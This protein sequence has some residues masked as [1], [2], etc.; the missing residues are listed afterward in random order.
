M[1]S[2]SA[3]RVFFLIVQQE[4]AVHFRGVMLAVALFAVGV[5]ACLYTFAKS[6]RPVG[7]VNPSATPEYA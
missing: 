5:L 2:K 1:L 3:V 4:L 7:E 6:G